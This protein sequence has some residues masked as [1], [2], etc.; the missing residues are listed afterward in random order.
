MSS[1]SQTYFSEVRQRGA[2]VTR[3]RIVAAARE[4]FSTKGYEGT[5]IAAVAEL[6]GV[7]APSVYGIYKSKEGLVRELLRGAAFG[8]EYLALVE[9]V[10]THPDAVECL[11]TSARITRHVCEAERAQLGLIRG[12]PLLSPELREIEAEGERIRYERQEVL[13]RR[14]FDADVAIPG[15]EFD[16][17][18]DILWGL[19]GRELFRSMVLERGWAP[20]EYERW[21][22]E[23][24]IRTL[25][26]DDVVGER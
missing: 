25:V 5:T 18:R 8:P 4:L 6:A 17:A 1:K 13:V 2:E 22:A 20:E 23:T 14:L 11:R 21:L 3:S 15:I 19:T 24:L 26:R 16:R 10:L 7:S 9:R 12:A